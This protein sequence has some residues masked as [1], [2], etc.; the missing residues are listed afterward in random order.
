MSDEWTS[1]PE[2]AE[3]CT[4]V[5][6]RP[7]LDPCWKPSSPVRPLTGLVYGNPGQASDVRIVRRNGLSVEWW[8]YMD[9]SG[10]IYLNPPYSHPGRWL[11][12]LE[13]AVALGYAVRGAALIKC[14]PSTKSWCR[15]VW[16]SDIPCYVGFFRSRLK[17]GGEKDHSANFPSALV[18]YGK[19]RD[20]RNS[21]IDLPNLNVRWVDLT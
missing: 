6:G 20:S 16:D 12:K 7:A 13:D 2:V 4:A 19:K 21:L 9:S 1:P 15:H 3:A 11:R 8:E 17:H 5:W 18:I 14:D 10:W